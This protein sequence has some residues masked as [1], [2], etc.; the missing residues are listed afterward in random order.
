VVCARY[1]L[2][3]HLK[4]GHRW[5]GQNRPKGRA[6]KAACVVARSCRESKRRALITVFAETMAEAVQESAVIALAGGWGDT[7]IAPPSRSWLLSQMRGSV[8]RSLGS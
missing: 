7:K 5:T 2:G 3:G 6:L 4:P 8:S 1:S